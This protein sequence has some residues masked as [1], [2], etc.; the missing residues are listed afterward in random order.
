[1]RKFYNM[2]WNETALAS[3]LNW[4]GAF[5]ESP[6]R[7]ETTTDVPVA[8]ELRQASSSCEVAA[9]AVYTVHTDPQLRT[10]YTG[11]SE[12]SLPVPHRFSA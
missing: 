8:F 6:M 4:G 9:S 10:C 7:L 3:L 5:W 1:M 11:D 12:P 2:S